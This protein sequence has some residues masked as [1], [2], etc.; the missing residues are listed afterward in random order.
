MVVNESTNVA[1][2][3]LRS[4]RGYIVIAKRIAMH[5]FFDELGFCRRRSSSP[6]SSDILFLV[7]SDHLS[8]SS[9]K[10]LPE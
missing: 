7:I 10:L 2:D 8:I 4:D 3:T 6:I 1:G 9:A 5:F